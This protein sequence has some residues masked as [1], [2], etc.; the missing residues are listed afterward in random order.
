[1]QAQGSLSD[2]GHRAVPPRIQLWS[3]RLAML[4][5]LLFGA[6][7]FRVQLLTYLAGVLIHDGNHATP[8]AVLIYDGDR[9]FVV[10]AKLV[11]SGTNDVILPSGRRNRLVRMG[12]LLPSE[13]IGRREL[14]KQNVPEGNIYSIAVHG[15]MDCSTVATALCD[16]AE[17]HPGRTIGVLCDRFSSRKW[18]T[19]LNRAPNLSAVK[20]IH[21]I[22]V[23]DRHF[24]ETNWWQSKEGT[25]AFVNGILRL[26]FCYLHPDGEP[27][28]QERTQAD[29]RATISAD[30]S[31]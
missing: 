29:F 9:C 2:P 16:W 21:V 6:W 30:T 4:S 28:W 1:M 13:E 5:G 26:T 7:L 20:R 17:D 31:Q 22:P 27:V 18:R 12:V 14:L 3:W 25:M 11:S 24:N 19:I 23:P 8:T 15:K 10:A